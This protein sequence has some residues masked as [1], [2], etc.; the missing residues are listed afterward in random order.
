MRHADQTVLGAQAFY[1]LELLVHPGQVIK[2]GKRV[3]HQRAE[4]YSSTLVE[5]DNLI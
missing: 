4:D 3:E 1:E 5:T 2:L